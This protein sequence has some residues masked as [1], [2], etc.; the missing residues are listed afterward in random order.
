MSGGKY[1]YIIN[2]HTNDVIRKIN[3]E[4]KFPQKSGTALTDMDNYTEELEEPPFDFPVEYSCIMSSALASA[5]L[6]GPSNPSSEIR[7]R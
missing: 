7:Q 3:E 6:C 1:C 5:F 2:F 4:N